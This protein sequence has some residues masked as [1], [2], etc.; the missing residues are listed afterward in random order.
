M[1]ALVNGYWEFGMLATL[2]GFCEQITPLL[3]DVSLLVSII[4]MLILISTRICQAIRSFKIN[5]KL[6]DS[7]WFPEP[8]DED[9]IP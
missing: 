3:R 7:H 2:A 8:S 6:R 5:R 9:E 4:W 1:I